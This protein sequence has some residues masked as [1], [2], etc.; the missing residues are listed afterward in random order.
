VHGNEEQVHGNVEHGNGTR[1]TSAWQRGNSNGERVHG[2]EERGNSKI[3]EPTTNVV[4]SG[5]EGSEGKE[6][7]E[8]TRRRGSAGEGIKRGKEEVKI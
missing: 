3:G 7:Q 4:S 6:S 1:G 8:G 2:N 5:S